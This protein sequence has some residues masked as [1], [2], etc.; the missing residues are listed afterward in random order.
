[1][2][3]KVDFQYCGKTYSGYVVIS[4]EMEPHYYWLFF[5]E[6][7]MVRKFGDG[8]GFKKKGDDLVPTQQYYREA[9]FIENVKTII[10]SSLLR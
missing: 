4:T 1:M 8:I 9:D 2:E 7:E 6:T 10:K 3:K 5:N